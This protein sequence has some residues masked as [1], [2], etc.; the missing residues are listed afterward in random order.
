M[1]SY[2]NA[3]LSL[4]LSPF[5]RLNST[6]IEARNIHKPNNKLQPIGFWSLCHAWMMSE[7]I[8]Q[9]KENIVEE[10]KGS[11]ARFKK[12]G[13]TMGSFPWLYYR[14]C[15]PVFSVCVLYAECLVSGKS[16]NSRFYQDWFRKIGYESG[17]FSC[18]LLMFP[19]RK[20]WHFSQKID[21]NK[22]N[23]VF[24]KTDKIRKIAG[25]ISS[26]KN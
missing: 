24:W 5:P 10:K 22:G 8:A 15:Q 12:D 19:L 20:K 18:N 2:P 26:V 17:F 4:S 13:K 21:K 3:S 11:V 23:Y 14:I 1:R 9:R 16:R 6:S 7:G 25:F